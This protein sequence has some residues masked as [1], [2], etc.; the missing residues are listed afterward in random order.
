ME[1]EANNETQ[2]LGGRITKG[3]VRKGDY[4]LRP[5]CQNHLFVH[6]VLKWLERK[7]V[8]LAPRFIGMTEDGREITSFLCGTSPDNLQCYNDEQIYRAGMII[9][10]LHLALRD[11]AGCANGQTVCHNDLSPCNFMFMNE[12]PYAVFDWDAAGIGDPMDDI[13]YAAWMWCDIGNDDYTPTEIS[14]KIGV[15]LD[16][17]GLEKKQRVALVPSMHVQMQRVADSLLEGGFADGHKWA[18]E[19]K[20]WLTNNNAIV[21]QRRDVIPGWSGFYKINN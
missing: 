9:K 14:I 2:L 11:F 7:G 6:A 13:A 21:N 5:C 12:M 20:R 17:Y 1:T 8:S 19:C 3:V 15:M 18:T 10:E 16:A 4:V